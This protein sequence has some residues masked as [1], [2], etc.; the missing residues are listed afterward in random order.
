MLQALGFSTTEEQSVTAVYYAS[1]ASYVTSA[2]GLSAIPPERVGL[3]GEYD[4]YGLA[5]R[6][7]AC[8]HEYMGQGENANIVVKQRGSAVIL[9]GSIGEAEL[10]KDLVALAMVADGVTQVEVYNL[11]IRPNKGVQAA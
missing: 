11:A 9:T 8:F 1:P 2:S 10:L 4:Y 5:H 7:Q 3:R 6:I